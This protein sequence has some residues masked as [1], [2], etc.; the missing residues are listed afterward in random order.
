MLLA[1]MVATI[2][3]L[4]RGRYVFGIGAGWSKTEYFA[5]GYNFPNAVE[6]I[7]QLE[8][9][10]QIVRKMWSEDELF[11][12]GKYYQVN[13]AKCFPRPVPPPSI[14]IGGGGEKLTLKV[15]AEYADWW[16]VV[17]MPSCMLEHKISVLKGYC[18]KVGR[19]FNTIKK[20]IEVHVAIAETKKEAENIA[21]RGQ[22]AHSCGTPEEILNQFKNYLDLGFDYYLL[23]FI[24][25]PSPNG[26][27]MFAEQVIP[28]LSQ[29]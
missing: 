24:D 15:V 11:F 27:R 12:K 16:N 28:E 10:V 21:S 17:A 19:D 9:A 5:Y 22:Q 25:Q 18:L 7:K 23:R 6:R 20:T 3:S 26:A 1:K 13:G 8:E 4:T 14:M 2:H 29:F